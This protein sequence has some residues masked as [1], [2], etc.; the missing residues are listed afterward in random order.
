MYHTLVYEE[1][2]SWGAS[3]SDQKIVENYLELQNRIKANGYGP[4]GYTD[5]ENSLNNVLH[6]KPKVRN[7]K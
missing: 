5:K 7:Y 1:Q 2:A 6:Q 3:M 4:V